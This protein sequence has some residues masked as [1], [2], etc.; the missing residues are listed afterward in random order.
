MTFRRINTLGKVE[1]KKVKNKGTVH[2]TDN[3]VWVATSPC[4]LNRV[5]GMRLWFWNS[6]FLEANDIKSNLSSSFLTKMHVDWFASI[7]LCLPCTVILP[8]DELLLPAELENSQKYSPSSLPWL[9]E[10]N[11]QETWRSFRY[12]ISFLCDWSCTWAVWNLTYPVRKPC[13]VRYRV[14]LCRAC[15]RKILALNNRFVFWRLQYR[16]IC[17]MKERFKNSRRKCIEEQR[18]AW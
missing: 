4:P 10:V 3:V 6:V 13:N 8:S 5:Q 12:F 1:V 15:H 18:S 7:N 11:C 17:C 16:W 2:V 9:A 14:T